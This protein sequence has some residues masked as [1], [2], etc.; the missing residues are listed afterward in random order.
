DAFAHGRSWPDGA[1]NRLG[2][3]VLGDGDRYC[4]HERRLGFYHRSAFASAGCS[5]FIGGGPVTQAF[6]SVRSVS[7]IYHSDHATV[8]ALREVSLEI[9]KGEF[10]RLSGPSGSGK[11]TLLNLVGGLDRP[12]K[13]EVLVAG[14]D[15][16]RLSGSRASRYRA[17]QVGMVFQSYNLIPQ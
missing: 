9:E 2:G 5:D 12:N 16:G 13:G 10:V 11:T 6:V 8:G 3:G 4:S 14:I 7:K 1:D 17:E 15:V